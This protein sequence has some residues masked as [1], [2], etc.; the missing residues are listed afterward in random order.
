ME[1]EGK[2][3]YCITETTQERNFGTIGIGQRGDEVLTIGY[4]DLS[5]VVSS[6]PMARISMNRENMLSHQKVIEKVMDEFDGVLPVRFGT[7]A[8]SADEIR[9][10]LDRR[11]R[12][13]K[14]ALIDMNHKVELGVKGLWKNMDVIF[15]EIVKA[16]RE[17]KSL[18]QKIAGDESGCNTKLKIKVGKMVEQA[19]QK[20]KE[21]EAEKIVDALRRTAFDHKLNKTIGDEMFMNAAF[22]VDK[23]REKEFDNIMDD[24]SDEYKNRV[25]FMYAGPLPVFNFVNIVIYP[26][27]W[28][29]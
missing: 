22:L 11:Y 12:E 7:I 18:K 1:K 14:S 26:E 19:L 15:N 27:E 23:G 25:K 20:K 5:M 13:F 21:Q 10:L 8:A 16:N 9:G 2:Y 3:I 24:L 29:K 4:D 28:E 17:I 6:Y